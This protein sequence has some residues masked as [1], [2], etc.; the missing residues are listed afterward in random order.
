METLID[1]FFDDIITDPDR[2]RWSQVCQQCVDSNDFDA[3]GYKLS[4]ISGAG[5]ICGVEG[6]S[7]EADYYIDFEEE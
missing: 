1:A 2:G 5:F 4:P 6:C 7:R 3:Q